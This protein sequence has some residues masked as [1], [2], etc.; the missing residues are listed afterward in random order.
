MPNQR[1][2]GSLKRKVIGEWVSPFSCG[3][4]PLDREIEAGEFGELR[5]T[6]NEDDGEVIEINGSP[7]VIFYES[8]GAG[9]VRGQEREI[10]AGKVEGMGVKRFA[11]V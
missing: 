3:W 10:G 6:F 5:R 8:K 7:V 9:Q 11:V 1:L 4:R 2:T